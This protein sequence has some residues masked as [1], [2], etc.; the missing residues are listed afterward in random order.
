[1]GDDLA[2]ARVDR[3]DDR[4]RAELVGERGEQPGLVDGRLVDRDLVGAG[5][6]KAARVLEPGDAA[7]DRKR[8]LELGGGPLDQLEHR[9]AA[10]DRRGDVEEDELVGAELGV[11]R[12]ELDRVADLAQPFEADALDHPAAGDVEA[13]DHALLDHATAFRRIRAPAAPLRS[14]WNCTP[15]T[16]SRSTAATTGPAW[17]TSATATGSPGAQPNECAK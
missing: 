14:G 17:S 10:L 11:A 2:G 4:L 16:P 3:A 8:D 12:R 5:A 1:M 9:A 13:G 7:A 6:E 15:A